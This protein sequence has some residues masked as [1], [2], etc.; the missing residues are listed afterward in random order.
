MQVSSRAKRILV[1]IGIAA[2]VLALWL[3]MRAVWPRV[4]VVEVRS[5]PL[6]QLEVMSGR[7]RAPGTA[8][9]SAMVAGR[10][11]EVPVAD[12]QAVE[13][14]TLLVALDDAELRAEQLRAS[15]ALAQARAQ[16]TQVSRVTSRVAAESQD[17]AIADLERARLNYERAKTL[18][19]GGALAQSQLDDARAAYEVARS[20]AQS[21]SLQASSSGPGGTERALAQ[22]AVVQAEAA[23]FA[24][25]S[26]LE[27]ARVLAPADGT[28]FRRLVEPGDS[29]Q[30]GTEVLVFARTT[31]VELEA[32]PDER[33]LAQLEVGQRARVS[34]DAFPRQQFEATL[35][36]IAAAVDPERGTVTVRFDV[37]EPP[38]YLRPDMTVSIS[39]ETGRSEQ[40]LVLPT[41]VVR[42]AE[43]AEPWVLTVREGR[44]TRTKVKVGL[45]G[46]GM[47]EI[48]EGLQAGDRV[49][50]VTSTVGEGQRVRA[51]S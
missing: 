1:L 9:L 44:A 31:S 14:G 50:P 19:E 48:T 13:Q 12:G 27:H 32:D 18:T 47:V 46:E 30:P 24:A 51:G 37:A 4:E 5:A 45:E 15:G 2:V 28:V 29:V 8:T 11:L 42:D 26:R 41:G 34:A 39:V 3:G 33:S 21:A 20:R 6:V 49:I 35:R 36:Y 23:L 43:S 16:L 10:V 22:A 25:Q 40:A 7:V 17:Q 38:S